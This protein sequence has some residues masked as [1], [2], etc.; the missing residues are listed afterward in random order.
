MPIYLRELKSN[1]KSFIIW[2]IIIVAFNAMMFY[3]YPSFADQADKIDQLLRSYPE[4]VIKA[5]GGDRLNLTNILHYFGM[6]IY[7]FITLLGSTYS[8]ILSSGIISKEEDEKTIEFLLAKPV[9]REKVVTFK[10]LAVLT[11]IILINTV[12]L[13]TNYGMIESLKR[14]EYSIRIFLLLSLA[15]FFLQL[16]FAS[17]GLLLSVFIT[18]SRTV[19]SV[20]LGVVLG[21]YF[22]GT[23]SVL[24]DKFNGLKYVSLF[25]FVDAPDIIFNESINGIYLL[26][27]ALVVVVTSAGT[28]VTYRSRDICV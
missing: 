1:R 17:I 12:M 25:K 27:M 5:V 2:T 11:Y 4:A 3:T 23:A 20:S 26:V 18:K 15:A 16:T 10:A 21:S 22:F 8:I 9:S 6:N 19:I 14:Y 28:Y 24:S 13:A 7:L